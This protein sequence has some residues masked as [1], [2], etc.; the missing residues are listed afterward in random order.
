[1]KIKH[2]LPLLAAVS[3]FAFS[4]KIEEPVVE[5]TLSVNPTSLSFAYEGSSQS[6]TVT[7]NAAQWEAIG[8]QNWLTVVPANDGKT[9]AV[10]ASA[11]T[12]TGAAAR[13][14]TV[15]VTAGTKTAKVSVSQTAET[16]VFTVEGGTADVP[17]EGASVNVKVKHNT[18]YTVGT[19]PEWITNVSTKAVTTDNLKFQ[20]AAN[21]TYDARTADITFTA[22]TGQ[23]GKVT[24]KQ[25]GAKKPEGIRT[26][27]EL[28]AWLADA[29]ED[30]KLAADIDMTG[31]T[32]VPCD[33]LV[34]TLDGQNH[35]IKNW[36]SNVPLVVINCGTVKDIV[37][38]RSCVFSSV[39]GKGNTSFIVTDN[40]GTVENCVN[41]ADITMKDLSG[42]SNFGVI[43]AKQTGAK[44]K[45]VSCVN[46]GN[47]KC[48]EGGVNLGGQNL[49]GGIVG[50]LDAGSVEKCGNTGNF[51]LNFNA[52]AGNYYLG[53]VVGFFDGDGTV[54]VKEC[55]NKGT[56]A[57]VGT[58]L[59]KPVVVG[60]VIGSTKAGAGTFVN[61]GLVK[62]CTNEGEVTLKVSGTGYSNVGGVIAYAEANLEGCSNSG[63]VSNINEGTVA[64]TG[65]SV[66]GVA[67]RT[68]YNVKDCS[69][70][71]E[72]VMK[73]LRTAAT[74]KKAF[75]GGKEAPCMGGVVGCAGPL[76][77]TSDLVMSGCKNTSSK[78]NCEVTMGASNATATYIGAVVGN[79]SVAVEN[80]ENSG[81]IKISNDQHKSARLGGIAGNAIGTLK[82]CTNK[83][84][85]EWEGIL[86]TDGA[87]STSSGNQAYVGGIIG[88]ATVATAVADGC[89][90][91]GTVRLLQ[92][93]YS[94]AFTYVGGIAGND[95][96][97]IL[98]CENKGLVE[99]TSASNVRVAGI[100]GTATKNITACKNNGTVSVKNAKAVSGTGYLT[101][102]AGIVAHSGCVISGCSTT[103]AITCTDCEPDTK[104][105]FI[106][107]TVGNSNK[108]W[109]GVSIAGEISAAGCYAGVLLG[110][111]IG[112]SADKAKTDITTTVA[113]TEAITVSSATKINGTAVTAA[114]LTDKTKLVGFILE[115]FEDCFVVGQKGVILK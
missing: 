17:A 74:A 86:T 6:V 26:A 64:M 103:G 1:M 99:S 105:G 66:G 71:G 59:A 107:G 34:K 57:F 76:E 68:L 87:C 24:V 65:P 91:E 111:Q 58:G 27:A 35:S 95:D 73:G 90:N 23:T 9:F 102:V 80:C 114:D 93:R 89:V 98:N 42:S 52:T 70:S 54:T 56:V 115:G 38:D 41:N 85:V 3:I 97:D 62:D 63:K 94:T 46:N 7:T 20:V 10:T 39:E 13:T 101:G 79:N 48:A 78:F 12:E 96:A 4:C 43:V 47:L 60:G 29:K 11:Y 40:R 84:N 8:D 2:I 36:T 72:I 25:T 32:L 104:A 45:T 82:N 50:R 77:A 109:D 19:L 67:G 28:Q 83:G 92:T 44:A 14:A 5:T 53:G 22:A 30:T 112:L 31:V 75:M 81:N 108:T 106:A 18:T 21:A 100:A 55:W 33:S 16:V 61:Y 69:N 49:H 15:T 51:T 88:S 37:L 110:G 113:Q